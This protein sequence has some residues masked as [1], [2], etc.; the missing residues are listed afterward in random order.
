MDLDDLEAKATAAIDGAG[1]CNLRDAYDAF[2][3]VAEPSVVLAL[4]RIARAA[5]GFMDDVMAEPWG[6]VGPRHYDLAFRG[7]PVSDLFDALL[8]VSAI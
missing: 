1:Y 7:G 8:E 5:Q 4:L 2:Q 6:G 3:D